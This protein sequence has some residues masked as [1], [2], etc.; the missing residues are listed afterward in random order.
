M[1][2]PAALKSLKDFLA[3]ATP[4]TPEPLVC[5]ACEGIGERSKTTELP[6]LLAAQKL[7]HSPLGFMRLAAARL[8]CGDPTAQEEMLAVLTDKAA[9][10]ELRTFVLGFLADH[11]IESTSPML[12]DLAVDAQDPAMARL[13]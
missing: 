11:P 12:A 2:T 6:A 1:G 3:A 4:K 13:R 10:P 7:V 5:A 9:K 8:Q